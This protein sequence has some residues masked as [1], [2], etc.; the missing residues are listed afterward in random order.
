[1]TFPSI[2]NLST[3]EK[4]ATQPYADDKSIWCVELDADEVPGSGNVLFEVIEDGES[5]KFKVEQ[6]LMVH[7]LNAG[8]C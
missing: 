4:A 1:M 7:L 6:A 2:D 8:G 5:N 3:I